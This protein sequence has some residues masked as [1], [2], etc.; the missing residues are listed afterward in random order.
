M[1]G[2]YKMDFEKFY[3][4]FSNI[5]NPILRFEDKSLPLCAAET[6]ISD[7]VRYPLLSSV[8]EKY[9]LGSIINYT[10]E[11][12]IGSR[13]LFEVYGLLTELC[14]ELFHC[15]YADGRTLTGVNTIST[16]LM[17]LFEIDDSIY[18]TSP[19]YG[20]HSSMPK[21]CQRLGIHVIEMPYDVENMD[22]CYD[23]INK[24]IK[25]K[26][27]KGILVSLSDMLFQPDLSQIDL[28]S[29][30]ILIYDATQ[31]L[32]LIASEN[33]P[34]FFDTLPKDLPFILT[35]S[36]HKT[37]PGPTNGIILTNSKDL[38]HQLDTKINPDYLRNIQM[39]Q[40]L[41]LI[42]CLEEFSI[43]GKEYM[44]AVVDSSNTLAKLLSDKNF[45]VINRNSVYSNTHQIFIHLPQ[46]N[47]HSFYMECQLYDITL[48]ER[49]RKIY[50]DSGI[51]LGVQ[52]IARY[53]W[54]TKELEIISEILEMINQD[55]LAETHSYYQ[56]IS[57]LIKQLAKGKR[58]KFTLDISNFLEFFVR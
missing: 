2:R 15:T 10:E 12:F 31:V 33:L 13:S 21:I 6:S 9:I 52:Q 51:R 23:E 24:N 39:H 42:F 27:I 58:L 36:T 55:C 47:T 28:S 56:E 48:N 44:N 1:P 11:N 25:E 19:E 40:I 37:L 14:K 20:G 43:Y 18:I 30:T 34:N 22:F 4:K 17:S 7:F 49:Y 16:L 57:N 45:D 5:Y 41:S 8:Q 35:G 50:K 53:G 38:M 32:G 26:R 29:E 54:K 46:K 3:N